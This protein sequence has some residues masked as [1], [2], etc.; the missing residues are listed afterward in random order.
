ML[1]STQSGAA[2]QR[3]LMLDYVCTGFKSVELSQPHMCT[4]LARR[5]ASGLNRIH[6]SSNAKVVISIIIISLQ[7]TLG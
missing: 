7:A 2:K 3:G 1:I 6:D 4:Q 5:W